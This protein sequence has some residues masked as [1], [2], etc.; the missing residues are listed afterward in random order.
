[1]DRPW[2]EPYN[3]RGTDYPAGK[4][5]YPVVLVTWE[6]AQA[7]AAWM[8]KRLPTEAE[9]EKASRAQLIS[10]KY[11]YGDTLEN[12][13]ANFDKGFLRKNTLK[14]VGSFEPSGVGLYDMAGNV[15]E[16]C[17][18]WYDADLLQEVSGAESTGTCRGSVPG[19]PGRG[20][21]LTIAIICAAHSGVKT[22]LT[23]KVISLDFAARSLQNQEN[24]NPE[25]F[26][27]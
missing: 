24:I 9:W 13:W 6:D 26:D 15:W 23:A 16:W 25:D 20:S 21:G 22:C 17:Q 5:N 19:R 4:G 27:S 11:P 1:M 12:N 8:S 3:W 14:P 7:Y 10:R 18:D 2:A